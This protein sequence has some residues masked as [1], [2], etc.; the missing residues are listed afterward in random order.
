MT[1]TSI[2]LIAAVV[3]FSASVPGRAEPL[4]EPTGKF[5][6]GRVIYRLVDPARD[7]D[8]GTR[9]DGKRDLI[10]VVWYPA[11][12]GAKGK[13]VPWMPVEWGRLEQKGVLGSRLRNSKDP[14]AKDYARVLESVV[15]H[16]RE[17]VPL[18]DSPQ[19]FPVLLLAPGSLM[20]APEYSALA[21]DLA[22]RGFVVASN[23]VT[24]FVP[25][26]SPAELRAALPKSAPAYDLWAGD[27]IHLLD[28]AAVWNATRTHFFHDRLDLDH[29]GA[30]GHS[31]GGSAVATA[32][33]R[34]KRVKA[35][36]LLDPGTVK[37]EEARE[38]PTLLFRSEHAA[39]AK[40]RPEFVKQRTKTEIDYVRRT[41]PGHRIMLLE[42]EHMSFTDLAAIK[43]F[44]LPGDGKAFV[45]TVRA[46]VAEAFDQFLFDRHSD[47]IEKG[48][49][50]YPLA[51]VESMR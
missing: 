16:S 18:A 40:S 48:S 49:A 37:P 35:V 45:A 1:R 39:L 26:Y 25:G 3:L 19:R 47:L 20:F 38:I 17:D 7:G 14:D 24:G 23:A 6:V 8:L 21:E 5:P 15:V 34:D 31:A 4:P 41:K 10:A 12:S 33:G 51:K 44:G 30:F 36:V 29:V 28:Q 42:S 27:V 43:A 50:K 46:V 11:Q 13:S 9:K 32:A 2:T 22:S